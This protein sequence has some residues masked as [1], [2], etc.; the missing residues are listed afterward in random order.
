MKRNSIFYL[1]VFIVV[2]AFSASA[3]SQTRMKKADKLFE[4]YQYA[5][6]AKLY[7]KTA[8]GKKKEEGLTKT[9]NCY[10]MMKDYKMAEFYYGKVAAMKSSNPSVYYYYAEALLNNGK[11]EEANKQLKIFLGLQ[12]NDKM[13]L[14]NLRSADEMQTWQI[15]TSVYKVY[16]MKG[17]NSS[18][19]DFSPVLYKD[20]I[21]YASELKPD[22]ISGNYNFWN[23]QPNLC[24]FLSKGNKKADSTMYEQG[25]VFSSVFNNDAQNGPA[26]FNADHTEMFFTRVNYVRKK[27]KGFVNRPKIYSARLVNGKPGDVTLLAFNSDDYS[28]GHPS[29]SKD[30]QI[31][32]FSSNMPGGQGGDDLWMVKREGNSWGKPVNLGPDINTSG[33][34]NYPFIASDGTLYFASDG[35]LGFGGLDIFSAKNINGKWEHPANMMYPVNSSSDDFSLILKDS[36]SGYFSSNRPGGKGGDDIYGF[37]QVTKKSTINGKIL[38]SKNINDGVK[39]TQVALL[40]EKGEVLQTTNTD[41]KGYFNFDHIPSD[42]KYFVRLEESDGNVL[43]KDKYYLADNQDRI[44]RTT[45]VGQ[46]GIFVFET[47]P[48]DLTQLKKLDEEDISFVSIAGNLLAGDEKTPLSNTKVNLKNEKGEIVQTTTTNAFGSFVFVGLP[49]DQNFLVTIETQDADLSNKKIYFVNKSGKEVAVSEKGDFKFSILSSD[50]VM[51]QQII[52]K[53]ADLRVDMK[54]KILGDNVP[55]KGSKVNMVNEKGEIIQTTTTN[56][57]GEFQFSNL[58]SDKKYL[59]VLDEKDANVQKVEN[60]VILDDKGNTIGKFF[61]FGGKFKWEFLPSEQKTIASIYVD[62]PWLQLQKMKVDGAPKKDT[63]LIIENIYYEYG[64]WDILPEAKIILDKVVK[65]MKDNPGIT[66][67][68]SSHTDSR[69]T[70]DYNLTLSNKRAKAT[71]AYIISKGIDPKRLTG[72]GYGETKLRNKCKDG[73]ECSEDEHAQ[74]RRTEFKINR[75]K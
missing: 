66:I 22:M 19:A 33:D 46:K 18:Y 27:T 7:K 38:S 30:G 6:A 50:K 53:D 43:S 37:T 45:V 24:L 15:Q 34:E 35:H 74:N 13:G 17:M 68:L 12:P 54:G 29:L 28:T 2:I 44:V 64:K 26:C 14:R 32:Y 49:S 73:V 69:A 60:L 16:N 1:L 8:I 31:L 40:N 39:N 4:S 52:V 56:E 71:V 75:E 51:L 48:S 21:V 65:V 36:K 11:Y 57:K 62:D 23:G 10:R 59:V 70:A 5:E 9:G 63:L 72:K 55:M 20:G 41:S 47:L 3:S 61:L 58:P 67:D 42:R 25:N